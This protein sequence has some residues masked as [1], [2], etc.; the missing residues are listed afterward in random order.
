[1]RILKKLTLL[2]LTSNLLLLNSGLYA[3]IATDGTLGG[4]K[5]NL[6]GPNF[7]IP[8]NLG[9][10]FGGNLFHS[11]EKFNI[12]TG[13]SATFTGPN[14]VQNILSRVT[15]GQR[16]WIDGPLRSEIPNANLYLLNPSGILFGQNA[17]LDI[18]GSFHAST[19]DYL[20]LT[21]GSSFYAQPD[22]NP[23][24]LSVARPEAFGFLSNRPAAIE[25]QGSVL[26][27][28]EGKDLSMIGGDLTIKDGFLRAPNGMI[29][30]SATNNIHLEDSTL[31]APNGKI[32]ITANR[33]LRISQSSL[34][35]LY[36][37]DDMN[38][39]G[40]PETI[41]TVDVSGRQGD[42]RIFIRAGQFA[43]D[44]SLIFADNYGDGQG[45]SI[46]IGI[47]E[48]MHLTN[49]ARI[50]TDNLANGLGGNLTIA[51]RNLQL[52]GQN[53]ELKDPNI[54]CNECSTIAANT[55]GSGTGGNIQINT[56]VLTIS[57][58]VIQ[59]ATQ[60]D[61]TA[62]NTTI[63]A[64]KVIL[65]KQ[66]AIATNTIGKGQGGTI[67]ITAKDRISLDQS[68][69]SAQTDGYGK[70]G[71]I[72]I[73]I[74]TGEL[75]L[76]N[77]GIINSLSNMKG[78]N[79]GNAG[80]INIKAGIVNINTDRNV[81]ISKDSLDDVSGIAVLAQE[82]RGGNIDMEVRDSLSLVHSKITAKSTGPSSSDNGGNIWIN[83]PPFSKLKGF[84]LD[85][86]YLL[87]NANAGDGGKI[88][89]W[90]EKLTP[91]GNN[92]ITVSSQLGLY[93]DFWLNSVKLREPIPPLPGGPP[94]VKP[95]SFNR[96]AFSKDSRF[97]ITARDIL[98][99]CPEDLRTHTI[100][101]WR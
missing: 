32:N 20:H 91:L 46:D 16:S 93:G 72:F 54:V 42:G 40:Q 37:I 90:L 2:I 5:T 36:Q 33:E 39:D 82:A 97:I 38:G 28:S 24:L 78:S 85:E 4:A 69:I 8:A 43:L 26:R 41:A 68:D 44:K 29:N 100:R 81:P 65:E 94:T 15:G 88:G 17:K 23:A 11:F 9:Q 76:A 34:G 30:V 19:A 35:T 57:H 84:T 22:S 31:Y 71:D 13:Q 1:M 3:Q 53:D 83:R 67:K 99:R 45:F 79:A 74:K 60:T 18:S 62:G 63:E 10:Q 98:P 49:G 25:I 6:T 21:D 70:A 64:D 101:L 77:K 27:V 73:D 89:I 96:C 61:G 66:G 47:D 75:N 12:D 48:E 52:S 7:Q 95:F 80:S 59:S 92:V 87:A 51:A 58:G 50:T 86:G 14:T 56:S 55:K